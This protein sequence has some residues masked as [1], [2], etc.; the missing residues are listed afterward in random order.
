[1]PG[2][3]LSRVTQ[4]AHERL[5]NFRQSDFFERITLLKPALE[6]RADD[7]D[8]HVMHDAVAKRRGANQAFFRLVYEKCFVVPGL[9]SERAQ[10]MQ[11]LQRMV[12]EI[13]EEREHMRPKAFA[14][15]GFS[16]RGQKIFERADLG[17]EVFVSFHCSQK[18]RRVVMFIV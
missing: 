4:P 18:T 12:F 8:E 16:G 9:I 7:V 3:G 2:I 15:R 10:L 11:Q 5:P 14:S 6:Q 17:V 13:A 1:M